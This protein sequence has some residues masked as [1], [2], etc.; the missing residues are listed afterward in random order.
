MKKFCVYTC[1]TGNYDNINEVNVRDDDVDFICYT[2]NKNLKS[3]T[4]KI[5][6][7]DNDGLTDHQLS[8][9]IKMLG[10]DYIDKKYDI[11]LW[12]D[13]SVIWQKKPSLFIKKYLVKEPF[14][15]IK[16]SYRNCI[17]EEANEI[18]RFRKASKESIIEHVKFLEKENFP[19]NYGLYEMTIFIKKHN[20]PKVKETMKLWYDTY[21]KHSNR[22]QLSFMYAVW[23]TN[24]Q[25]HS[26]DMNV[27]DNEWIKHTRHNY[28]KEIKDCRIYYNDSSI[29]EVYDYNLDYTYKYNIKDNNYSFNAIVPVDTNIMEI[30]I[31][32]VP[33]VKYSDFNISI[34]YN[35]ITFFN[36]IPYEDKE[37]FYNDHG[38]VRVEGNFKKGQKF[39]LSC[40]LELLT[41]LE[42]NTFIEHLCNDIIILSEENELIKSYKSHKLF[43]KFRKIRAKFKYKK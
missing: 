35:Q 38:V 25:I 2:N 7:V 17:Y 5:I 12:Q 32:N 8:R 10:T 6:Y 24:L 16:H 41:D 42:K 36:V 27:W 34:P 31:V 23:K 13:A 18:V 22:D 28:K 19:H 3:K 37:I 14:S 33:C 29:E 30:D 20:D 9:K 11:S 1:I 26:I 15:S 43:N 40:N 39:K 4:W 21:L